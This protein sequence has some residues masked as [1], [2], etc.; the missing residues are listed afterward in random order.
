MHFVANELLETLLSFNSFQSFQPKSFQGCRG[1]N[2]FRFWFLQLFY[3]SFV[4]C[5][6]NCLC[7]SGKSSPI[8]FLPCFLRN[9][10]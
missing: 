2:L 1:G 9:N 3:G 4:L 5:F 7:V 10:F 6:T 8:R